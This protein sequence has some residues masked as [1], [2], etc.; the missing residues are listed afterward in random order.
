MCA[1]QLTEDKW[2]DIIKGL[3]KKCLVS[4][5]VDGKYITIR[6]PTQSG[7]SYYN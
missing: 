5:A 2:K 4:G 3:K 7:S 1:E 6:Q